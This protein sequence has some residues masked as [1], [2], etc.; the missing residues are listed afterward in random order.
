MTAYLLLNHLLNFMAPA[1][2]VALLLVASARLFFGFFGSNWALVHAPWSQLAINFIV[3]V[4]VL[5]AGLVLFGHDG[6]MLTYL[7]LVLATAASQWCLMG[8]WRR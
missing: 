3:G 7:A 8:G 2:V 5:A 1:M 6:K 4:A